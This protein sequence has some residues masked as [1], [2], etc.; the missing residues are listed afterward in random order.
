MGFGGS[1]I[2]GLGF[3]YL[4]FRAH[5]SRVELHVLAV[6][7]GR[8]DPPARRVQHPVHRPKVGGKGRRERDGADDDLVQGLIKI[9]DSHRH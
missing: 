2:W 4:G 9:K 3:R 6:L 1:G 7:V 8:R 5:L